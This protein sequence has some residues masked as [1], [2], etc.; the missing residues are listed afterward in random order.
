MTRDDVLRRSVAEQVARRERV[1]KLR[2]EDID[3]FKRK[4]AAW[5]AQIESIDRFLDDPDVAPIA[6]EIA[7]GGGEGRRGARGRY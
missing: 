6:A 3:A 1:L 4:L 7:A 2:Q 5:D